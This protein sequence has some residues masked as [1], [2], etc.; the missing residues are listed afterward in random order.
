[1]NEKVEKKVKLK[2]ERS[3]TRFKR[4]FI[5]MK[6]RVRVATK[7]EIRMRMNDHAGKVGPQG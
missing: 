1:M 3:M 5:N 4:G 2:T 6:R 7:I